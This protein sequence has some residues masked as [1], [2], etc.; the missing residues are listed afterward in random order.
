MPALESIIR[1][2]VIMA[3]YIYIWKIVRIVRADMRGVCNENE[4]DRRM[5]VID[6]ERE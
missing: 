1:Y 5:A 6:P 3:L 2:V 4:T